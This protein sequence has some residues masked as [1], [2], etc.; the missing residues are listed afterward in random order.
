MRRIRVGIDSYSYHRLLGE[1]RPGEDTPRRAF[2]RGSVDVLDHARRLGVDGVS[3]ET[4]FLPPA[5]AAGLREA[6][7]GLELVLAW[8]HPHGL[9]FGRS[10]PALGDL[11][12]WLDRAAAAEVAL[13][14]CVAAS[15]RFR[16]PSSVPRDVERTAAALS[17]AAEQADALGLRLAVENHADLQANE[18]VRLLDLVGGEVGVCFDTANALRVGDDPLEAAALLAPRIRMV[19]L[20]DVEPLEAVVDERAGPRSV[21]YGEG[22][23]PVREVL[24]LLDRHGF[25]GLVCVE[26]GQLAPGADE[27]ALVE[28]SVDWLRSYASSNG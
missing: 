25:D 10:E 18:L 5:E 21:P 3:L 16:D 24:D 22:V 7:G 17:V 9:E 4:C 13:V 2:D 8:G 14:R 20:K 27:C 1:L 15:P 19:H 11:L 28:R 6:A 12:A 26:L 23:V